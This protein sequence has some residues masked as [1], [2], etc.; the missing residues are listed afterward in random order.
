MLRGLVVKL[1]GVLVSRVTMESTTRVARIQ[2]SR[3]SATA[4]V[5][6]FRKVSDV[7]QIS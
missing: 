4:V 1:W 2:K 5:M 6:S 7:S 3:N